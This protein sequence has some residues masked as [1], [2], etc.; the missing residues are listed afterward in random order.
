MTYRIR[1]MAMGYGMALTLPAWPQRWGYDL[2]DQLE[3]GRR[4]V[5]AERPVLIRSPCKSATDSEAKAS[6][7]WWG[8][9][10]SDTTNVRYRAA[11]NIPSGVLTPMLVTDSL[12]CATLRARVDSIASAVD[13]A[14]ARQNLS[15]SVVVIA[16]GSVILLSDPD[17]PDRQ[18]H[19][20]HHV[21]SANGK[22]LSKHLVIP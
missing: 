22:F 20:L 5:S 19:S 8:G 12:T 17:H 2:S 21:F 10:F 16:A 6:L 9:V 13:P 4:G 14:Y 15:R 18:R 11:N 7:A 1:L 3:R